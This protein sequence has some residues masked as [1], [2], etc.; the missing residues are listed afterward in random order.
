MLSFH[1]EDKLRLD[2]FRGELNPGNTATVVEA[3]TT[4]LDNP[5]HMRDFV[6]VPLDLQGTL[7]VWGRWV[8]PEWGPHED[9]Y[10]HRESL[11]TDTATFSS[12]RVLQ[13]SK[14]VRARSNVLE[15]ESLGELLLPESHVGRDIQGKYR[16]PKHFGSCIL[17]ATFPIFN[18]NDVQQPTFEITS[19]LAD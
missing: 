2:A 18:R 10:K 8:Q 14:T 12:R 4:L 3:A 19:S 15:F 17:K 5:E 7:S 13:V 1:Q 16:L 9:A 6:I 11:D